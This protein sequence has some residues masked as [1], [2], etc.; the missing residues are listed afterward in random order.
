MYRRLA[1]ALTLAGA[2]TLLLTVGTIVALAGLASFAPPPTEQ[3][4]LDYDDPAGTVARDAVLGLRARDY[5][6]TA[7]VTEHSDDDERVTLDERVAI[8][9]EERAYSATIRRSRWQPADAP[10][11]RR[12]GSGPFGHERAPPEAYGD[13]SWRSEDWA[14]Y[15]VGR[16]ALTFTPRLSDATVGAEV[17]RE[18]DREYIV[19]ITNTSD[20][21]DVGF[22]TAAAGDTNAANATAV[23][24]I[25][26]DK[27][28][29]TI[30][31]AVGRHR[32]ADGTR[33]RAVYTFERYGRA[34]VDR[35]LG[36][37][38]PNPYGVLIRADRGLGVVADAL[39]VNG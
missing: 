14:S 34:D 17:V 31:R 39:G 29:G 15:D 9:N 6:Y 28:D 35:P 23:L 19:R 18:T 11:S 27:R 10:P 33:T 13:G 22:P 3:P 32:A 36:A 4:A 38:P 30:E 12:F 24:T 1:Q 20:A 37:Y 25:H 16:N 7:V 5:V 8:E 26:I 21:V 2:V